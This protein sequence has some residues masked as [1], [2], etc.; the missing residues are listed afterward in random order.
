MVGVARDREVVGGARSVAIDQ[1]GLERAVQAGRAQDIE[2][3]ELARRGGAAELE[4][5]CRRRRLSVV[6]ADGQGA[7]RADGDRAVVGQGAGGRE[8]AARR[9]GEAPSFVARLLMLA[10]VAPGPLRVMSRRW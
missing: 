8:V 5:E 7:G 10:N 9:D 1:A 6:A 2:L 3:P 4:V